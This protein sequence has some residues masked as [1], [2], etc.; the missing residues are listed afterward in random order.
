MM[1][2]WSRYLLL[3]GALPFV[4]LGFAHA[5]STPTRLDG[6]RGLSPSDVELAKAMSRTRLRLTARTD[7]WRAWMGFN[8]SRSLGVLLLGAVVLVIG[9]STTSFEAEGRIFVPFSVLGSA[10]YLLLASKYWFRTPVVACALS[11]VLFLGSW[12]LLM[13]PRQP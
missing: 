8:F 1:E 13:L 10:L 6:P 11:L 2:D 5:F 12:V 3:A 4:V 7:M 9:R